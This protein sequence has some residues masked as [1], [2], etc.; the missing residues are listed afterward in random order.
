[1]VVVGVPARAGEH[2]LHLARVVPPRGE[3]AVARQRGGRVVHAREDGRRPVD[4]SGHGVPQR[5]RRV[6]QEEVHVAP[7]GER[8]E[9]VAV[10]GGQSRQA[11]D[12]QALRQVDDRGLG[13]QARARLIEPLGRPRPTDALAQPQPQLRLPVLLVG[14]R[15]G[16]SADLVGPVQRVAV[17]QVGEVTDGGEAPRAP[18]R[19]G[20]RRVAAEVL[21]QHGQ[22][23]LPESGI[24]DVEQRP[25]HALGPPRVGLRVDPRRGRHRVGDEAVREREVDVRADAVAARGRRAEAGRQALRDPALD[26]ARG[27][28]DDFGCERVAG[29]PGEQVAQ[30]LDEAVGAVG[31]MDVEHGAVGRVGCSAAFSP[32]GSP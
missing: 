4:L 10:A 31:A 21:A 28:G 9:H 16:P 27:H 8:R 14:R 13:A 22:P 5:R 17:E 19:V 24:D 23:R 20:G 3:Q 12:R 15:R 18:Q 30:R 11:E 1:M 26:A 6:Q 25:D 7:R 2:E 32:D 29:R